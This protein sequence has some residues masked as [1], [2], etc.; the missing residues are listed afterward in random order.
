MIIWWVD[1]TEFYYN[2][3]T[4]NYFIRLDQMMTV[5]F[6]ATLLNDFLEISYQ[7]YLFVSAALLLILLIH[8]INLPHNHCTLLTIPLSTISTN[9]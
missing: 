1:S 6:L 7:E 9:H 4:K 2:L 3:N 5:L 8:I